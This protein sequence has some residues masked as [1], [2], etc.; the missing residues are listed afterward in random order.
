MLMVSICNSSKIKI[1]IGILVF[2]P[3]CNTYFANNVYFWQKVDTFWK[4][5]SQYVPK[6]NKNA[7]MFSGKQKQ[8]Y[9]YVFFIILLIIARTGKNRDLK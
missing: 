9:T 2:Y 7:L 6:Q 3:S 5:F 1:K 4:A 8:C